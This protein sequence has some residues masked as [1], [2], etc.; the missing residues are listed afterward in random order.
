MLILDSNVW[1]YIATAEDLP[2]EIYSETLGE[3]L[4]L[5]EE[6]YEGRHETVL[7]AYMIE[8]IRQG[9]YRSTRVDGPEIDE[10]LTNFFILIQRC[11]GITTTFD[12]DE[13]RNMDLSEVRKRPSTQ[14]LSHLLGI[15]GKDVPIFLLAYQYRYDRPHILTDDGGFGELSPAIFGL[16]NITVEELSLTW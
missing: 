4:Y 13:L 9:L 6:F 15:Q 12:D 5:T 8:E 16:Q 2:V 3:R 11:D 1:I 14:L 7:S 10:A